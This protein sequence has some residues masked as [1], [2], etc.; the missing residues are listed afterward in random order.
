MNSK[1]SPLPL[2][3]YT[4]EWKQQLSWIE[5][6][7]WSSDR[8]DRGTFLSPGVWNQSRVNWSYNINAKPVIGLLGVFFNYIIFKITSIF[9]FG[10]VCLTIDKQ[11]F[12]II[13]W[14]PISI[15]DWWTKIH[16]PIFFPRMFWHFHEFNDDVLIPVKTRWHQYG[17]KMQFRN[18]L[19]EDCAIITRYHHFVQGNC[20]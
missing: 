19:G 17:L 11:L 8:M 15:S 16:I 20:I 9:Y 1:R 5:V 13:L 6:R 2:A 14:K 4:V 10:F 3:L 12:A 18:L 7:V